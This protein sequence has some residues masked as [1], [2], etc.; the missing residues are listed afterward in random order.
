MAKSNMFIGE[1]FRTPL[2][3]ISYAKALHTADDNDKFSP[4]LIIP[5]ADL[6]P[7]Q[8]AIAT[9]VKGQWG[10]KGP[11]R[12]KNE[13]IKNPILKGDSKS[14]R[15][16]ETGEFKPGMGPDVSFIRPW[17]KNPIKTFGPDVLPMDAKEIE[18]GWYG[19]AVVTPFCWHNAEQ[20]DGISFWISMWQ[21]IR[22]TE[23]DIIASGSGT[24]D[25]NAFFAKETVSTDGEGDVGDGGAAD[26]FG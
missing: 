26:L 24:K 20:G 7:F 22:G 14:A 3:R 21:H 15:N 13:L 12:F 10:E 19:Y 4:T 17:S 1:D 11:E 16:K 9:C 5:N 8:Q 18:S 6:G 2:V 25:P 23:A